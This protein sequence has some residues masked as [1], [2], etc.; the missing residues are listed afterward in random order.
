MK[1]PS[2]EEL[3]QL[4]ARGDQRAFET[5][6]QRCRVPLFRF[7]MHMSGSREVADEISQETFL[8]L[9]QKPNAYSQQKGAL[10]HF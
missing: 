10:L 3:V 8:F 2:D 6:Y 5:V 7:A 9:L 1:S 4:L